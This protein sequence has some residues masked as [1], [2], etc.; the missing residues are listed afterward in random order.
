M[1]DARICD[2][3]GAT[4]ENDFI[5]HTVMAMIKRL[6]NIARRAADE[7]DDRYMVLRAELDLTLTFFRN[8]PPADGMDEKQEAN[9]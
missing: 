9:E 2:V 1:P 3:G 6:V 7:I 4:T 5:R 8:V